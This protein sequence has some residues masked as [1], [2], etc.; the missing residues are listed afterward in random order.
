MVCHYNRDRY[1]DLQLQNSGFS[2]EASNCEEV[3]AAGLSIV[4]T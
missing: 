2:Y 3:Y 4:V 1:D